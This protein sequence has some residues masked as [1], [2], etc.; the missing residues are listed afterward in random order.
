MASL[1][2]VEV[3]NLATPVLSVHISDFIEFATNSF[4]TAAISSHN[5]SPIKAQTFVRT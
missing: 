1:I 3:S 2:N 5:I 4:V